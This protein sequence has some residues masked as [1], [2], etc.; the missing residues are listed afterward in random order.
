[1]QETEPARRAW[2]GDS[3]CPVIREGVCQEGLRR[4]E[5]QCE[6]TAWNPPGHLGHDGASGPGLRRAVRGGGGWGPGPQGGVLWGGGAIEGEVLCRV[7]G[8]D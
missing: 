8:S 6:D 3:R 7:C 1:M 5:A 4:P 2:A